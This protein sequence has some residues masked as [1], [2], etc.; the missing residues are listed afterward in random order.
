MNFGK[1]E[2][3]HFDGLSE[4]EKEEF[5]NPNYQAPEGENWS[6]VRQRAIQYFTSLERGRH[7][8]FTHGGL[9]CAYLAEHGV[10]SMPNNC[11]F[12]GVRMKEH[13]GAEV[14]KVEF[15]WEFP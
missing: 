3:L 1:K 13:K 2:G 4:K 10:D 9:I 8:I 11:S 6:Q 15:V 12:I 14:E 5:R 7:L